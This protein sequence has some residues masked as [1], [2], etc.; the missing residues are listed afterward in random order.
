M[1]QAVIVLGGLPIAVRRT[2]V[3][4]V[5]QIGEHL[6]EL[7]FGGDLPV[8]V[9]GGGGTGG[10]VLIDDLAAVRAH[11]V[12]EQQ[13]AQ[14]L[15]VTDQLFVGAAPIEHLRQVQVGLRG[16]RTRR[17]VGVLVV[18]VGELFQTQ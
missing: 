16:G 10:D 12:A 5:G 11:V 17:R 7:K 15:L 2:V 3:G 13:A 8:P 14:M 6:D 9:R 1:A 4:Q 18:S